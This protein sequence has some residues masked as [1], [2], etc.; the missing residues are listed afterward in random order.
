MTCCAARYAKSPNEMAK[1]K[2]FITS[3][4]FAPDVLQRTFSTPKAKGS[5][6]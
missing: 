3:R 2:S 6:D 5:G 1:R 4:S